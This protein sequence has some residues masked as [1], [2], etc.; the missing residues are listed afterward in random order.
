MTTTKKDTP[1]VVDKPTPD[2]PTGS[3]TS[4]D[5]FD[6]NAINEDHLDVT[7]KDAMGT[8]RIVT[9]R[10]DNWTPAPT[11]AT[12]EQLAAAAKREAAEKEAS[13]TRL[14]RLTGKTT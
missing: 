11:E 12:K 3:H 1:E 13:E 5:R 4:D 7:V 14:G 6:D 9:P 8:E 2:E 10:Q